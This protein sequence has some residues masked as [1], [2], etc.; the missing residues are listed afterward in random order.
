M[1][2]IFK[3]PLW[4]IVLIFPL[5]GFSTPSFDN[6]SQGDWNGIVKDLSALTDHTAVSPANGLQPFGFEIGVLGGL[7]KTPDVQEAVDRSGASAKA[8]EWISARL[9]GRLTLPHSLTIEVAGLPQ[10]SIS[11]VSLSQWGAALQWTLTDETWVSQVIDVA[12]KAKYAH[13]RLFFSQVIQNTST[14][15]AAVDSGIDL[16]DSV[17]GLNIFAG[18]SFGIIEPYVAIG[19]LH[20]SG[21]LSISSQAGATI[22][23]PSFTTGSSATS[24]ADS[25][26]GVIGFDLYPAPF[27]TVGAEYSRAF[28]VDSYTAKLSFQLD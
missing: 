3:L 15:G 13:S 23:A 22:F 10:T 20:A 18:R 27:F 12:L 21:E 28:D 6:L 2:K 8:D 16:T 5:K 17:Y 7:T 1:K 26:Q 11:G 25:W 4:F 24:Q 19:Y 14:G 9:L